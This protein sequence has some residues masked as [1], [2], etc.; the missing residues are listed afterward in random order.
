MKNA[1]V[2]RVSFTI[3]T[4]HQV[5]ITN[6]FLLLLKCSLIFVLE[7]LSRTVLYQRNKFK[8]SYRYTDY[9]SY[10]L[11]YT[12]T[13]HYCI[14]W[15]VIFCSSQILLDEII[16]ETYFEIFSQSFSL[17]NSWNP[18]EKSPTIIQN[19]S[20]VDRSSISLNIYIVIAHSII[21]KEQ[22]KDIVFS[23]L[24]LGVFIIMMFSGVEC[25]EQNKL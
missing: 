8:S 20:K 23:V 21:Q 12:L 3:C 6:L 15:K 22:K 19:H 4:E 1:H 13:T 25:F 9:T 2:P 14:L 7:S 11:K 5:F 24:E 17:I 10:V 16:L 18:C